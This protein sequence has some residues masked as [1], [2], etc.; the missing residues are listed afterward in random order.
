MSIQQSLQELEKKDYGNLDTALTPLTKRC[1][2]L[3]KIPINNFSVEDLR[4]M[5]SQSI[6]LNHL[7]PLAVEK[8]K[9]DV[10]AEGDFY[11]GDL[12]KS[13]VNVESGF[14]FKHKQLFYSLKMIVDQEE[15]EIIQAGILLDKLKSISL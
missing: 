10:F 11:P 7:I 15:D 14:W 3:F 9:E 8:L 13:V 5:I 4:I 6:G 12:L 1:I 2:Q